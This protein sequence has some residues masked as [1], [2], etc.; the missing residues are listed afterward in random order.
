MSDVIKKIK[1]EKIIAIIR[2]IETKDILQTATALYNGG[3]K[4][5]E[6]TFN[7]SS[8]TG[9]SDTYEAIKIIAENF[10]EK[11]CV[12][13]GTVMSEKQVELAVEAGAKYLISPNYNK[14]VVAKTLEL[15]AISMPGV[16][17]PSEIA[18]AYNQGASF[19]K[20][21]PA[22]NFGVGYI[23]AIRGPISHIPMLA[24]GGIDKDNF[25]DYMK[26]GMAGIG[27][28]SCLVNKKLIDAGEFEEITQLAKEFT[29]KMKEIS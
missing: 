22:G 28:G 1:E 8:A 17:T 19:A 12:G 2:G 3:I 15:G 26:A 14:E 21:F 24:V 18:Q 10:G 7:Q 6:V 25:V 5:M 13:A 9:E 16:I 23:K 29:E 4:L 11:V 20:I 27:V